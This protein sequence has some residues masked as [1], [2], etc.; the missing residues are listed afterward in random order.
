MKID[1]KRKMVLQA[2]SKRALKSP[3]V[4]ARRKILEH[5]FIPRAQNTDEC[6]WWCAW[7]IRRRCAPRSTRSTSH[8]VDARANF[9]LF[10][11]THIY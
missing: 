2:S 11:P 1:V 5:H 8:S 9:Q 3:Q 7:L 10:M 4:T 6:K